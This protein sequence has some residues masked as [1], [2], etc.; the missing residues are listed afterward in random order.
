MMSLLGYVV[1][2]K[3]WQN[4]AVNQELTEL[5]REITSLESQNG[6]LADFIAYLN[7][8]GYEETA[9]KERLNLQVPG[10]T[11]VALPQ[12]EGET[13]A[14]LDS[15]DADAEAASLAIAEQPNWRKWWEYYFGPQ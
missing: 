7:S 8:P 4:H 10:E 9:A 5:E 1:I 6:E 11:V 13:N 12:R 2:Q 15:I 14:G 3:A